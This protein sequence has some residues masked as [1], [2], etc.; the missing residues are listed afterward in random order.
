MSFVD[1]F[2]KWW[3]MSD[4]LL[5]HYIRYVLTLRTQDLKD[6]KFMLFLLYYTKLCMNASVVD[7]D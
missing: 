5:S 6:H 4:S 7:R 1:W 3:A 2:H